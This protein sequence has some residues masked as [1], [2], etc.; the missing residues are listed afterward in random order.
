MP[1]AKGCRSDERRF[2]MM[3]KAGMGLC[4]C[5]YGEVKEPPCRGG[6][7]GGLSWAHGIDTLNSRYMLV[8]T[9][10]LLF[11]NHQVPE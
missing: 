11:P 3:K 2:G 4:A 9:T 8:P 10:V 5:K 6:R 7:Q 1:G